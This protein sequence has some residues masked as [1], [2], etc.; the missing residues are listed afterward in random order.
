MFSFLQFLDQSKTPYAVVPVNQP[1]P[2]N[3]EEPEINP[4]ASLNDWLLFTSSQDLEVCFTLC[5]FTFIL[6]AALLLFFCY[7]NYM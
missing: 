7:I 5:C 3:D 4:S 1:N 2:E 6:F